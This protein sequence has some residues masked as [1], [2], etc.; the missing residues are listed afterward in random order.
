MEIDKKP[1]YRFFMKPFLHVNSRTI[2]SVM[3]TQNCE[4]MLDKFNVNRISTSGNC[5]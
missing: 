4:I 3:T 1:T 2:T 5:A